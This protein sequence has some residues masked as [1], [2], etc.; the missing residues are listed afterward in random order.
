MNLGH[1]VYI[2]QEAG[3]LKTRETTVT[4]YQGLNNAI[5]GADGGWAE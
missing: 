4:A 3:G 1:A 2:A 5:A